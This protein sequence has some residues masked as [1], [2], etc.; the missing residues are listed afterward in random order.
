EVLAAGSW[1]QLV[2]SFRCQRRFAGAANP[3]MQRY[4]KMFRNPVRTDE[5]ACLANRGPVVLTSFQ[6]EA[7]M[8]RE[9]LQRVSQPL[10]KSGRKP[11]S[12]RVPRPRRPAAARIAIETLEGRMLPSTITLTNGALA[13]SPSTTLAQGMRVSDNPATHRYTFYNTAEG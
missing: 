2:A 9:S 10:I 4:Y 11:P 12:R 1:H 13:Y 8:F 7:L 6:G 3:P 5:L